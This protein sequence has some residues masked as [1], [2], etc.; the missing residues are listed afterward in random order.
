MNRLKCFLT[1]LTVLCLSA[2]SDDKTQRL[3]QQVQSLNERV[4]AL[5]NEV[6]ALRERT[7]ELKLDQDNEQWL[8]T[9]QID[10][11]WVTLTP[12]D[13][14][15]RILKGNIHRTVFLDATAKGFER[16]DTDTGSFF[17]SV[18]DVQPYL[19]GYK[20]RLKIGNPSSATFNA[21]LPGCPV[22]VSSTEAAPFYFPKL[23]V[24]ATGLFRGEPLLCL[25]KGRCEGCRSIRQ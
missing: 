11:V 9:N 20:L 4:D 16:I 13:T 22:P 7:A 3:E 8:L 21:V 25:V 5:T 19:D 18:E 12:L 10:N 17:I 23:A 1:I 6:H 24:S 2:C 15:V 14:D